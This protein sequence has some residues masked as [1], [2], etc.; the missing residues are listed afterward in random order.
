MTAH[1]PEEGAG[2]PDWEAAVK[3]G[4]AALPALDSPAAAAQ[5][6]RRAEL[7]AKF[8]AASRRE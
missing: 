6:Q 7:V 1:L 3:A 2:Y 4:Q 8:T 5:D